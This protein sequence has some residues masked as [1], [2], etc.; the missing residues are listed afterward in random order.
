MKKLIVKRPWLLVVAGLALFVVLDIAF[1]VIA[2]LHQ[3]VI[4]R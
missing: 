4:E 2:L 3:P 1:L